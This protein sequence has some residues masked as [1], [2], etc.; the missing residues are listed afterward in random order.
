[1]RYLTKPL[2]LLPLL[3]LCLLA[4]EVRADPLVVNSGGVFAG[5]VSYAMN[6]TGPGFSV[7]ANASQPSFGSFAITPGI[8]N[9]NVG[10]SAASF[11]CCSFP[12]T[13]GSAVINGTSYNPLFLDG[14]MSFFG[15]TLITA[16]DLESLTIHIPITASGEVMAFTGIPLGTGTCLDPSQTE[17]AGYCRGPQL[18]DVTFT[19]QGMATYNLRSLGG[20]SYLVQS[21]GYTFQTTPE[22]AT[23]VLLITGLAA[24]AAGVRGR[25][26][27]RSGEQ[28]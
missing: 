27:D 17:R 26:K 19:G 28:A 11:T 1:M 25:R 22:P 6:L 16:A 8:I 5:T 20:N 4:S 18:F 24:V 13:A 14:G 21:A 7:G 3:T 2:Y 10:F 23:V 12:N 9:V 15:S